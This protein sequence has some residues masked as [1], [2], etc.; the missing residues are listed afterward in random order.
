MTLILL[1]EDIP[2]TVELVRRAPHR[3]R[4]RARFTPPMPK[5]ACNWRWNTAR[6]SFSLDLGLPDYDGQTLAGWLRA[7]P[8]LHD[9]PILALHGLAAG[10]RPPH[11]RKLWMQRLHSQAHCAR[12]RVHRAN[13]TIS[14]PKPAGWRC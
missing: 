11:G 5:P 14:P 2:D 9:T 3:A 1:V 13:R 8:S 10:D 6:R 4:L 12:Q 7:E